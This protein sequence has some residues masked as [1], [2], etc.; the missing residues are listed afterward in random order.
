[1]VG[2]KTGG[3]GVSPG[4]RTSG[5]EPG[6]QGG[7]R[8]SSEGTQAWASLLEMEPLLERKERLREESPEVSCSLVCHSSFCQ[9]LARTETCQKSQEAQR[10][11]F[12]E[13]SAHCTEQSRERTGSGSQCRRTHDTTVHSHTLSKI[14]FILTC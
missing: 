13:N 12:A 9:A 14:L 5:Q 6:V 1:M 2:G 10:M 4:A 7:C 8:V 11:W 3:Y